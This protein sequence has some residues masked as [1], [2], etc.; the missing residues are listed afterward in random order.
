MVRGS[1][2]V[3]GRGPLA[4]TANV[5]RLA[6]VMMLKDAT[7]SRAAPKRTTCE[8]MNVCTMRA[9]PNTSGV[10]IDADASSEDKHRARARAEGRV[11]SLGFGWAAGCEL[12]VAAAAGCC[13]LRV[14]GCGL[15]VVG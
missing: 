7:P 2:R 5:M 9:F 12:R 6:C 3:N 13:G 11:S 15:W 8:L 4:T 1:D 14:A 10:G